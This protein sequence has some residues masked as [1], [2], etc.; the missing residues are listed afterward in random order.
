MVQAAAEG[1]VDF[2]KSK[3]HNHKWHQ[4]LSL[5][6]SGLERRNRRELKA[7]LFDQTVAVYTSRRIKAE[8]AEEIAQRIHD[9]YHDIRETY[10]PQDKDQRV[11]QEKQAVR[12]D[13]RGWEARFG[14]MSAEETKKGIDEFAA[15]ME[16]LRQD[17]AKKMQA[18]AASQ[19]GYMGRE[20]G[21]NPAARNKKPGKVKK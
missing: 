13:I 6:L 21:I 3:H 8:A 19:L 11:Q 10:Y 12:Q 4:H 16:R 9:L 2:S 14:Q 7:H 1:L 17:T 20:L 15:A 18:Q 5:I